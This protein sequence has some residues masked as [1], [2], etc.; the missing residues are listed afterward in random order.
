ML[1]VRFADGSRA[2]MALAT[3]RKHKD[4]ALQGSTI[5]EVLCIDNEPEA[6]MCCTEEASDA[7]DAAEGI[8]LSAL[9]TATV[10][11]AMWAFVE[12]YTTATPSAIAHWLLHDI[13]AKTV[14]GLWDAAHF[15][16]LAPLRRW[17]AACLAI[18]GS[19]IDAHQTKLAM[20]GPHY[21]SLSRNR[22]IAGIL[23]MATRTWLPCANEHFG[24]E[25]M[26]AIATV[27]RASAADVG[28][29]I[30][31]SLAKPR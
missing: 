13:D 7:T 4:G 25:E 11:N 10:W 1:H 28:A 8:M 27:F 21:P 14:V 23:R 16:Q 5:M 18:S 2:H 29:E 15:F 30:D 31:K 17:V 6:L 24:E 12:R 9:P 19:T 22:H 26:M 3:I 20:F